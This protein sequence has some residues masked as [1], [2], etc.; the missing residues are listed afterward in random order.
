MRQ[1][2]QKLKLKLFT[3]FAA[4]KA[5]MNMSSLTNDNEIDQNMVKSM[6][7]MIMPEMD[8]PEDLR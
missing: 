6:L 2:T 4:G 1:I 8:L 3:L 5:C 7:S